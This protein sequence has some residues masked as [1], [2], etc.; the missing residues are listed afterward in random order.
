MRRLSSLGIGLSLVSGF[1]FLA[2][3]AELYY[4]FW[5]KKRGAN[6]DIEDNYTNPGRELLYLFCWKKPSSLSSTALN[7]QEISTSANAT[8]HSDDGHLY[9]HSN[10]GKDHLLSPFGGGEESMEAELIRLHSLSG[11]PRF[12]FTIKEETKEDLESEDGRSRGGRSRKS[13]RGRSLSDLLVSA[14]TPFLTPLSSPPFFTPPL[15]PLDCY[16]RHGFNPL[17]E[18]SKEDDLNRIRSSP[19]PKFKFLKDAE[20]KLLRKTLME[21]ALKAHRN[22]GVVEDVAKQQ[23]SLPSHHPAVATSSPTSPAEEENG[24]FINIV[25][26]KNREKGHLHHSSSSQQYIQ[27]K[28]PGF[29][30]FAPWFVLKIMKTNSFSPQL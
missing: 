14:E 23:A 12:L 22:G 24:S 15:T 20:E 16:S 21:E 19:P 9:L 5:W 6:G 28:A 17:F 30:A 4:L 2:L 18:S 13:S 29:V 3:A 11:P 25:I 10:S 27:C 7:P 26:A 1:L 8:D